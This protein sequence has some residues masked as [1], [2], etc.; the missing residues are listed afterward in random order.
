MLHFVC[1]NICCFDRNLVVLISGDRLSANNGQQFTTKDSD[2]DANSDVNCA[3]DRRG[4][5]WYTGC[6]FCNLNGLYLGGDY[7]SLQSN[8]SFN[9]D[10]GIQ[11]FSDWHG[12]W[13]SL[14]TTEMKISTP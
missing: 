3:V 7:W 4:A 11:W 9:G 12:S 6:E 5:W 13:Y 14:K 2:N 1:D 8:D 10:E